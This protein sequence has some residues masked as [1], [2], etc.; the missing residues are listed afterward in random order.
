[1]VEG[2]GMGRV[3]V[4]GPLYELDEGGVRVRMRVESEE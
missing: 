2:L 1:M 4:T 3:E